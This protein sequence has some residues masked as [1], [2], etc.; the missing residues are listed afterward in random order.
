MQEW[1]KILAG[2]SITVF[3]VLV[4]GFWIGW[5]IEL[6]DPE[7]ED[8]LVWAEQSGIDDIETLRAYPFR[9][10]TRATAA[11]WY[12]LLAQDIGLV[13]GVPGDCVFADIAD[14]PL[15]VQN[16]LIL[17]CQYAFFK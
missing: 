16:L 10:V 8:A 13:P 9:P 11:Q 3:I 1:K 2:I 5:G 6:E 15:D 7:F 17:S 12:V 4:C 14:I